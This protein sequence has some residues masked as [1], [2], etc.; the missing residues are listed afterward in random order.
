MKHKRAVVAL[1]LL[2]MLLFVYWLHSTVNE[3]HE[4]YSF[5][6]D[7]FSYAARQNP[8]YSLG[9][10]QKNESFDTYSLAIPTRP[11]LAENVTLR[12]LLVVPRHAA[13]E[14]L[15]G[16]VLLP[17]GGGTKESR[18]PFAEVFA[19]RGY[20]TLVLDQRGVGETGGSYLGVEEDYRLFSQGMEPLQHLAVYDALA[21]FDVLAN[22]SY[23]DREH[24]IFAGESMGGRYALIAA[25]LETKSA[26]TIAVSTAGFHIPKNPEEPANSYL[27]SIDPD[28]YIAD[29][30]PH[31]LVMI[32]DGNDSVIQLADARETFNIAGQ[33]KKFIE[34][35]RGC[36][37]GFCP[38]M[39]EALEEAL[40]FVERRGGELP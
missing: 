36:N 16:V 2:L 38:A 12:A 3:A 5:D 39:A 7:R 21:A 23:I 10:Y 17:G 37:H 30:A 13:D 15:P 20:V 9:L 8:R 24:I 32:H 31:P 40:D 11:L 34:H 18:L 33:P 19:R 35:N 26:G 28:R 27:R 4:T 6:G 29:I 25:A 1:V 14:K 22:R